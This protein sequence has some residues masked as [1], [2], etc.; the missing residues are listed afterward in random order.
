MKNLETI[1]EKNEL[2]M[3]TEKEIR[4]KPRLFISTLITLVYVQILILVTDNLRNTLL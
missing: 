3:T 1:P 4:F 2:L